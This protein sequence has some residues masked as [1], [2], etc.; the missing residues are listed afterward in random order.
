MEKREPL[1][2]VGGNVDWTAS[3][4]SSTELPQKIKNGTPYDSPILLLG[5]YS[6][7]S[8]TL[9]SNNICTSMFIEALF[10]IAKIWKELKCPSVD[11]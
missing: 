10:T 4:E 9:I 11:E 6:K 5:I 8:E 1:C 2:I 3:V 7:K